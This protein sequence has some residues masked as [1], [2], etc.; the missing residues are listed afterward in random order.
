MGTNPTERIK[1]CMKF[2]PRHK[3]WYSK[4]V[5]GVSNIKDTVKELVKSWYKNSVV[6]DSD[7]QGFDRTAQAYSDRSLAYISNSL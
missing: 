7:I 1:I 6:K 2:E 5:S 4:K 3:W